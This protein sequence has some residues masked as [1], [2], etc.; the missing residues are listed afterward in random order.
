M[1]MGQTTPDW[2]RLIRAMKPTDLTIEEL[3]ELVDLVDQMKPSANPRALTH[4]E[5]RRSN[6]L[7]G[8]SRESVRVASSVP[9]RGVTRGP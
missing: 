6:D 9:G 7:S 1:R 4:P 8:S 5:R 3:R 2:V